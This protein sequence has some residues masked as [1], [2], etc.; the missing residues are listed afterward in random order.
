MLLIKVILLI[1]Y[2]WYEYDGA[3]NLISYVNFKKKL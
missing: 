3:G 1:I 2:G